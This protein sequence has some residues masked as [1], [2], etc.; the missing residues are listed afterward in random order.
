MNQTNKNTI[1]HRHLGLPEEGNYCFDRTTTKWDEV[2]DR[3]M[4]HPREAVIR[5]VHKGDLPLKIALENWTSPIPADVVYA[6]IQ[7]YPDSCNIWMFNYACSLY[8]TSVACVEVFLNFDP[9][10]LLKIDRFGS[11]PLHAA[12][13]FA[14]TDVAKLLID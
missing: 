3:L 1:L 14:N 13:G 11:S 6:F 2:K 7:A 12:A 10:L 9:K 8:H 5:D 4:T